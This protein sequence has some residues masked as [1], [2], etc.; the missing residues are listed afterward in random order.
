M[1]TRSL[2]EIVA[3]SD[4]GGCTPSGK[5]PTIANAFQPEA[6]VNP[7]ILC[8]ALLLSFCSGFAGGYH[9]GRPDRQRPVIV[10]DGDKGAFIATSPS[11]AYEAITLAGE[12]CKKWKADPSEP[13]SRARKY[14][15]ITETA[16]KFSGGMRF[17]CIPHRELTGPMAQ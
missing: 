12:Y 4:C 16:L 10:P 14:P 1:T 5:E 3:F 17:D 15:V 7:V 9:F 8:A 13:N 2:W 11:G 6:L